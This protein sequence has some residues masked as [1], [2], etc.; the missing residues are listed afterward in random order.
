M[1]ATGVAGL[2][3]IGLSA[4]LFGVQPWIAWITVAPS[5]LASI[6]SDPRY[7]TGIVAPAVLAQRLGLRGAGAL[8]W[9]CIWIAVGAAIVVVAGRRRGLSP[10]AQ[11][12]VV[13]V[14]SL[15]ATPYAMNY[16]T[17]LLAPG[18]AIA[19]VAAD[20]ARSRSFALCAY[21]VL[22]LAGLPN[23][24]VFALLAYAALIVPPMLARGED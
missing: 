22:A 24:G 16:E 1:V 17:T 23:I 13:V 11:M 5:Y 20:D 21:I 7:I 19:L 15:F 12:T 9:R 14:G 3:A 6:S 18:A 4:A 8:V 2:T 10:A